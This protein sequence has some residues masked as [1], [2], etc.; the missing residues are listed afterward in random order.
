MRPVALRVKLA[1]VY[2]GVLAV[3]L[4]GVGLAAHRLLAGQ[5]DAAATSDLQELTDGLHGYLRIDHDVVSLV[6]DQN[7]PQQTA[8]VQSATRFYQ[9]Y[10]ATTGALLVQS[11]AM[12]PLALRFTPAEVQTFRDTLATRD[13][14]TDQG[15]LRFSNTLVR[16]PSGGRYLLQVGVL[17]HG[18]DRAL[19]EF[20]QLLLWSIPVCVIVVTLLGRW[21]AGRSLAPLGRLAHEARAIGVSDLH[22]RLP[23]RGAQ[24]ELDQVASAFNETLERLEHSVGEMR[25]F[26][27]ALAH[28][29]RA[30]LAAWRAEVESTLLHARTTDDY[31]RG[32]VSQ[33]EEI[34]RL[35]RLVTHL[36]TLARAEAGEI[37]LAREAVD[38][39]ALGAAI[40]SQ[41]DAVAEAKGVTLMSD[42]QAHVIVTGDA[43]WI[44]RLVLNLLDN[45]IKFTPAGGCV[46][47]T[48]TAHDEAAE[49]T[50][51]DT[52]I[53]I[54]TADLPHVF[55]RFYRADS[56]RSPQAAGV[57]LGLTLAK[58]IAD[59]HGATITAAST[60]GHGS[61]LTVRFPLTSR[62]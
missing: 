20:L 59:R 12:A 42:V 43:G 31:Q 2:A 49:L 11:P 22:R 13:I 21:M 40:A 60:E 6:F 51:S 7:D 30:P 52:G 17:L 29:L 33:L 54:G 38:L 1:L 28:E 55:E 4:A 41:L 46:R 35:G 19:D 3:L 36:L 45:A 57:G 34:D 5:L 44:E 8:F 53:G 50:V 23:I 16:P 62:A 37:P 32:L 18:M 9:I 14:Q 15:R 25:Q 56:A 47:L 10:D 24:D 27:A 39:G 26:S 48:V 61:A 58:W